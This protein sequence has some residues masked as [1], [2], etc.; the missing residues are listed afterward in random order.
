M[1]YQRFKIAILGL[2]VFV[3]GFC[4][5]ADGAEKALVVGTPNYC[6]MFQEWLRPMGY[7]VTKLDHDNGMKTWKEKGYKLPGIDQLR[8]YKLIVICPLIS[9]VTADEAAIV[10][11]IKD[12]GNFIILYNSLNTVREKTKSMGYGICGFDKLTQKHL[13]PYP[14]AG[15]MLHKL[16]Y[17]PKMG[18]KKFE[19]KHLIAFYA[20]D[21]IDAEPLIVNPEIPGGAFATVTKVGK[22]QFIF[23]GGEN[24]ETFLDILTA[25]GL[26]K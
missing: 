17:T 23:Y 10:Q 9:T 14:K 22:G 24:R 4:M 11:Y 15:E 2:G 12:G 8:Q 25:C 16:E 20:E 5:H 6:V 21:L 1:N 7:N 19:R 3:C 18:N 13:H 26:G